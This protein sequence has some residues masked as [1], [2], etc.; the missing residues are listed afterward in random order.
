MITVKLLRQ[1]LRNTE[2]VE[3]AREQMKQA[4]ISVT[5]MLVTQKDAGNYLFFAAALDSMRRYI[6]NEKKHR[7][8]TNLYGYTEAL[9]RK[10]E[11]LDNLVAEDRA[12]LPKGVE[13]PWVLSEL[14]E[15]MGRF[16]RAV[17]TAIAHPSGEFELGQEEIGLLR[18]LN[19]MYRHFE[20]PEQEDWKTLQR[21]VK[22]MND[23]VPV[24]DE[25]LDNLKKNWEIK[26]EQFEAEEKRRRTIAETKNGAALLLL[27]SRQAALADDAMRK[28]GVVKTD[29]EQA[30]P[31]LLM[32]TLVDALRAY[33]DKYQDVMKKEDAESLR[34]VL[35]AVLLLDDTMA[36][37]DSRPE[38]DTDIPDVQEVQ[39]VLT[40]TLWPAVLERFGTY[41]PTSQV[42]YDDSR[43]FRL[44]YEFQNT[45]GLPEQAGNANMRRV[46]NYVRDPEDRE[47][48]WQAALKTAQEGWEERRKARTA[49]R[50]KTMDEQFDPQ[51][52]DDLL[53]EGQRKYEPQPEDD[54]LKSAQ[55]GNEP[56]P[57]DDLLQAQPGDKENSESEP[58]Q[59]EVKE[60]GETEPQQQEVKEGGEPESAQQKEPEPAAGPESALSKEEQEEQLFRELNAEY[61]QKEKE[62]RAKKKDNPEPEPQ[63]K[64]P[65]EHEGKTWEQFGTE[66][67]EYLDDHVSMLGALLPTKKD[68]DL[69]DVPHIKQICQ[70]LVAEGRFNTEQLRQ[71]T[72]DTEDLYREV[73]RLQTDPGFLKLLK[74]ASF[75]DLVARRRVANAWEEI[76]K[77]SAEALGDR[78]PYQFTI[79]EEREVRRRQMLAA[80]LPL[81]TVIDNVYAR[82]TDPRYNA[83]LRKTGF[84]F[85]KPA[86][87][88]LY[89]TAVA[90]LRTLANE[91]LPLTLGHK[92]EAKEAIRAYLDNRMTVRRHAYGRQRWEHMMC[93]YKALE[94]PEVF[95]AYCESINARRGLT[96]PK[97]DAMNPDYVY[98]SSFGPERMYLEK[99]HV[100]LNEAYRQMR[101]EYARAKAAGEQDALLKY[102]S[103]IGAIRTQAVQNDGDLGMLVDMDLVEKQAE[104]LYNE[105]TFRTLLKGN[106]RKALL[107][108]AVKLLTPKNSDWVGSEAMHAPPKTDRAKEKKM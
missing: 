65:P 80:E 24:N 57:E 29:A 55:E 59:Q 100:P 15:C 79:S 23:P 41:A 21:A 84:L 30:R 9:S 36:G 17:E 81:K 39:E 19:G 16:A 87:T 3:A 35:G 8:G 52:E 70:F 74:D 89:Q 54:L 73:R 45:L 27:N 47:S 20:L 82:L 69:R 40:T 92:R 53:K 71:E 91:E 25:L 107:E 32:L 83:S 44:L 11:E 77:A 51:P 31:Y 18:S 7:P 14:T 26:K 6:R 104:A 43:L 38:E 5:E 95:A 75:R 108:E 68:P 78:S 42:S 50:R 98:A 60:D 61:E 105:H 93:A 1:G 22:T 86:D 67:R 97:R 106:D 2:S 76:K 66:L 56:Q 85:F 48:L 12:G 34:S 90:S 101:K 72:V 49:A 63:K 103:K 37:P 4:G 64:A 88:G 99:P 33:H 102:Y 13:N 58:Q 62:R 94:E 46:Y 28:E 10:M 96:D